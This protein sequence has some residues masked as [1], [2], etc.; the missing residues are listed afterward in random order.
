MEKIFSSLCISICLASI[1]TAYANKNKNRAAAAS[2][3]A[4]KDGQIKKERQRL[5]QYSPH[6]GANKPDK[7]AKGS[8]TEEK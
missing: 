2:Q 4:A 8:K 6:Q 5:N 7:K 3:R 1:T